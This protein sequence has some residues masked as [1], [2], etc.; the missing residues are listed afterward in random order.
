MMELI[1]C[2][3]QFGCHIQNGSVFAHKAALYA[4]CCFGVWFY[5]S[6]YWCCWT[7]AIIFDDV[8][9]QNNTAQP[10]TDKQPEGIG[11]ECKTQQQNWGRSWIFWDNKIE[12]RSV[13]KIM[14]QRLVVILVHSLPGY[15]WN[16]IVLVWLLK[17]Y[18]C[19]N[20]YDWYGSMGGIYW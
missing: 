1:S 18:V 13:L 12:L 19:I 20:T 6:A 7:N 11:C 16:V 3:W 14:V 2:S 9:E 8:S 17:Y 4:K 15:H 10:K 5:M